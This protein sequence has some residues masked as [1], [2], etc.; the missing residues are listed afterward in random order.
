LKVLIDTEE[1]CVASCVSSYH[2]DF[3][4]ELF[5]INVHVESVDYIKDFSDVRLILKFNTR[6]VTSARS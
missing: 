4:V 5:V 6:A 1:G 3:S 2:R